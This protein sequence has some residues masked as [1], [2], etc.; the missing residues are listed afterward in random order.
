[1][2]MRMAWVTTPVLQA[3]P[4]AGGGVVAGAA[5]GPR[6]GQPVG[7][8]LLPGCVV[9]GSRQPLPRMQP[10]VG[11][12]AALVVAALL[13]QG[14]ALLP[15]GERRA[16]TTTMRT[17][18]MT[19]RPMM[20][21]LTRT[22]ERVDVLP[23]GPHQV[24]VI[25]M[26]RM[27]MAGRV[28]AQAPVPPASQL[29]LHSSVAPQHRQLQ[30]QKQLQ[31]SSELDRLHATMMMRTMTTQSQ[32]VAAGMEAVAAAVVVVVQPAA[33]TMK[34][35][36]TSRKTMTMTMR[37]RGSRRLPARGVH[38]QLLPSLLAHQRR[39]QRS[40]RRWA[41]AWRRKHL[42]VLPAALIAAAVR[43][44]RASCRGHR[45]LTLSAA[46]VSLACLA[47]VRDI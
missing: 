39:H 21:T 27:R 16:M 42:Q 25:S 31:V 45:K 6:V 30:F 1:M 22:M 37:C 12:V 10:L 35:C 43:L 46:D 17:M 15:A 33:M 28:G 8:L 3:A 44:R 32:P 7:V 38:L 41:V 13:S 47:K 11:S 40:G 14:L 36:S 26:R 29:P 24:A 9:V 18:M 2:T 20:M 19:M 34:L 23:L 5:V 4:V